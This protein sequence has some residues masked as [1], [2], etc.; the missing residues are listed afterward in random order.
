MIFALRQLAFASVAPQLGSRRR[1]TIRAKLA[2]Q[3]LAPLKERRKSSFCAAV[4]D[5]KWPRK[6][7]LVCQSACLSALSSRN[8]REAPHRLWMEMSVENSNYIGADERQRRRHT[9]CEMKAADQELRPLWSRRRSHHS[10]GALLP[11]ASASPADVLIWT[12][13]SLQQS[14]ITSRQFNARKRRA[15]R[16]QRLLET[17]ALVCVG[18]LLRRTLVAYLPHECGPLGGRDEKLHARKPQPARRAETI[19]YLSALVHATAAST[20]S[21]VG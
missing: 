12:R 8:K 2:L 1:P 18:K 17:G 10:W 19:C 3:Y 15:A 20:L 11:S 5:A 6:C 16:E 7:L 21:P 14:A 13:A 4:R 9:H